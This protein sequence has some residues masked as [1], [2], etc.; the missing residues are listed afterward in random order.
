MPKEFFNSNA[1]SSEL[2]YQVKNA[3]LNG[4]GQGSYDTGSAYQKRTKSCTIVHVQ[5]NLPEPQAALERDLSKKSA[6]NCHCN[7]LF[8]CKCTGES[9]CKNYIAYIINP[10]TNEELKV[11]KLQKFRDGQYRISKKFSQNIDNFSKIVIRFDNNIP[12][13]FGVFSDFR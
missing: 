10:K 5:G 7:G 9:G 8:D 1:V 2:V 6:C 11:G 4:V 12:V 3:Y 13:L